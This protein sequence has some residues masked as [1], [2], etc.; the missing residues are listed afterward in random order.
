MIAEG[1]IGRAR[2]SVGGLAHAACSSL[3][4]PK[5]KNW[6]VDPGAIA[7]GGI[8]L[9]PTAGMLSIGIVRWAGVPP[10]YRRKCSESAVSRNAAEE[11]Q[12]LRRSMSERP[13]LFD[14]GGERRVPNTIETEGGARPNHRFANDSVS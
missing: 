3:S 1:A 14:M 4:P 9:D 5:S 13:H 10:R 6:R 12:L 7:G 2:S 8:L 11:R